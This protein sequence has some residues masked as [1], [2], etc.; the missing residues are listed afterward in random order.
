M[1]TLAELETKHHYTFSPLF[2]TLFEAGKLDWMGVFTE[3]LGKGKTWED[4]VYPTPPTP[5]S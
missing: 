4:D 5:L 2:K 3:P 1:T